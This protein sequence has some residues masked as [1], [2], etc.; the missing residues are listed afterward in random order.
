[1][2]L[3]FEKK[4]I[5]E[6][7]NI[8][9]TNGIFYNGQF[10]DSSVFISILL[11]QASEKIFV[12]DDS[13]DDAFLKFFENIDD[14]V[15][16][17]I[18]T[19]SQNLI[20]RHDVALHNTRHCPINLQFYHKP[21]DSFLIIDNN[22]FHISEGLNELGEKSCSVSLMKTITRENILKKLNYN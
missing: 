10:F 2:A 6:H 5:E 18:Y 12:I 9:M 15:D 8:L 1:M 17:I 7:Q 4:E 21:S 20:L 13:L 19:Y 3:T 11:N 22:V 16:K 14:R